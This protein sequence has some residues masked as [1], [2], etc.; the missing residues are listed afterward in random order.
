MLVS[1]EVHAGD[2]P[3]IKGAKEAQWYAVQALG[4]SPARGQ[5]TPIFWMNG[6]WHRERM[7]MVYCWVWEYSLSTSSIS[8][9]RLDIEKGDSESMIP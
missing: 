8:M 4:I 5:L 3:T 9:T 6:R 2:R 1:W 7:R